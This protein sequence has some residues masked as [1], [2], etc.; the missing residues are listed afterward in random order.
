MSSPDDEMLPLMVQ[1]V[2]LLGAEAVCNRFPHPTDRA[3][4]ML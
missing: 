2:A 4:A 1:P 3:Y